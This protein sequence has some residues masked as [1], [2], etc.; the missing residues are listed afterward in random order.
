MFKD[1]W[2]MYNDLIISHLVIT[3]AHEF[4]YKNK[5]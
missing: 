3:Y 2:L 5:K 1:L 4:Y